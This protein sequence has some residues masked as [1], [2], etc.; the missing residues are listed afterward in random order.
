MKLTELLTFFRIKHEKP[1]PYKDILHLWEDDYLMLELLPHENI[2]FV[3][4]EAKR[5]N[6][7][8][9]EH[10]DGSGFTDITVIAEKPIKT[11]EKLIDISEV[12]KI[13]NE[14][15]LNKV[16]QFHTQDVGLIEGEKAPLGFG[17]KNFVILCD[18]DGSLLKNI[19][20]TGRCRH[21][22]ENKAL[23]NALL[24]FGQQFNFIAVNWYQG[25]YYNLIEMQSVEEFVK[26]SLLTHGN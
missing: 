21:E 23:I 4:A 7:F 2:E 6:N 15:G 3:K 24:S 22:E 19:S 10:F 13:M 25:E 9:R 17:T 16:T 14:V 20:I 11:I 8:G 18:K 1:Y 12:E 26:K 5:I